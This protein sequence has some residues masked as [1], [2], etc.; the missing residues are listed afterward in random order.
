MTTP[1]AF[2]DLADYLAIKLD[3]APEAAASALETY[4]EQI[5][6]LEGRQI[7][8]DALSE[9]DADF[10]VGAVRAAQRA[11]DLGARELARVEDLH[12]ECERLQD[13]ASAAI[14]ERDTAIRA[15]LGAGARVT[16]LVSITGL[17]RERIR[18]IRRA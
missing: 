12:A 11:G 16:D 9:D 7:D 3:I 17:S 6:T 14:S 2:D 10:L 15:A 4:I 1:R 18:Q 5:E 13:M 8:R